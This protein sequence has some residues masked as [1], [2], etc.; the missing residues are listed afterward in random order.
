LV[1]PEAAIKDREWDPKSL[2][3]SMST[4][5][6]R[7]APLLWEIAITIGVMLLFNF[8]PQYVGV[9]NNTNGVW[10]F[11]PLLTPAFSRYLPWLNLVWIMTI[12]LDIILLRMGR[13]QP[14]THWLSVGKSLF[15][16]IVL[17]VLAS[18]ETVIRLLSVDLTKLLWVVVLSCGIGLGR[19]LYRLLWD[20]RLKI[21]L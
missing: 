2:K 13:W 8:Y 18:G 15:S 4:E 20:E 11:T 12:A 1:L 7:V 16:V 3:A 14:L 10:T 6:V 5:R 17:I 21:H 19:K 9:G